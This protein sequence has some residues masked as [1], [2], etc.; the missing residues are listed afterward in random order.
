MKTLLLILSLV[1]L[2]GCATTQIETV[3][4]S[5]AS[6]KAQTS[7]LFMSNDKLTA[8]ACNGSLDTTGSRVDA[9]T[10]LEIFKLLL[11]PAK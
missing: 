6:C 3:S 1:L 7:S 5:G 4:K 11:A 2:V 8:S 10:A 9:S